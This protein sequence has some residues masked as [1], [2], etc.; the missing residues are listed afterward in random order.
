VKL[1]LFDITECVTVIHHNHAYG[2][3]AARSGYWEGPEAAENRK[4]GGWLDPYL[5]SPANATHRLGAHGLRRTRSRRHLRA[6]FEA[7]VALRPVAAPLRWLVKLVRRVQG[8]A[9]KWKPAAEQ[10]R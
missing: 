2:H 3:V 1:T 4:L 6:H 8:A 7:F 9:A 10:T 5:H